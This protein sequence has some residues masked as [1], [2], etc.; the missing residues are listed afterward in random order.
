MQLWTDNFWETQL[1][2]TMFQSINVWV[3]VCDAN[4]NVMVWNPTAER[5]SG[6]LADEVVGNSYI[7]AWLYPEQTYRN[8]VF[9][10]A[11]DLLVSDTALSHITTEILCRDGSSKYIAWYSRPLKD[12]SNIIQGFVTFGY[13]VTEQ[14]QSQDALHKV[15]T[16][17]QVLYQIA[18]ITSEYTNLS[19]IFEH[20]LEQILLITASSGGMIH[21]WNTQQQI[22]ELAENHGIDPSLLDAPLP[23]DQILKKDD[24]SEVIL[25]EEFRLISLPMFAKGQLQGVLSLLLHVE[26]EILSDQINLLRSIADQIGIAIDNAHLYQ[27]SKKLAVAE[28]RRRL[29]RDLHDSVSQSLY[30]LTLF[31]EAG[32]RML[33]NND[34]ERVEQYLDR[35]TSTA[36][37]ALREMRLLLFEL[38]PWDLEQG[39]LAELVQQRLEVVERRSG[40]TAHFRKVTLP[41]LPRKLEENVYY[42]IIEA[43]NNA[44]KHARCDAVSVEI[45]HAGNCLKVDI[46]DNGVGFQMD[47]LSQ[48]SGMGLHNMCERAEEFDGTLSIV[49]NT[50]TRKG[51]IVKVIIPLAGHPANES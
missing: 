4:L 27:R 6:Y 10:L 44:L 29:A 24:F 37:D 36:Q 50:N 15:N 26:Q 11:D 45:T 12:E 20:S 23:M 48:G 47:K 40:I 3:N 31:A 7:W 13:D 46:A 18:S 33:K 1:S 25:G 16:E 38:R 9:G 39:K 32:Q 51:T 14:K 43:L 2:Q 19:Q 21:L 34:T 41:S 35:L 5:I 49:P 42:I 8:W 30:S 17:L 28:E 22:L